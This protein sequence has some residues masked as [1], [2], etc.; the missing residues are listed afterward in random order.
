[1]LGVDRA[2]T[3]D[4]FLVPVVRGGT[5]LREDWWE[6][7]HKGELL[8]QGRGEYRVKHGAV[9]WL[10][11]DGRWNQLPAQ[12]SLAE[13][14]IHAPKGYTGPLPEG[15]K[16]EEE[17]PRFKAGTRV[18]HTHDGG[19]GTI[20]RRAYGDVWNVHMDRGTGELTITESG[21]R[22]LPASE[23]DV[24]RKDGVVVKVVTAEE[25]NEGYNY[26]HEAGRFSMRQEP[27]TS[28]AGATGNPLRADATY[29]FEVRAKPGETWLWCSD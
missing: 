3:V 25:Y 17:E 22:P 29:I 6:V 9:E 26:P 1:M 27:A 16:W 24:P 10:A 13:L 7:W 5:G 18:R 28:D 20:L 21:L 15:C 11:S 12:P 23:D 14:T 19:A 8:Q 4:G 2:E